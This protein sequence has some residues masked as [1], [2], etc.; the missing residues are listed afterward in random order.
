MADY[1][2]VQEDFAGDFRE[3]LRQ[4]AR[5]ANLLLKGVTNATGTVTLTA[6]AATTTVTDR[7]IHPDTQIK[8]TPTTANAATATGNVYQSAAATGSITLTHAN[9]GQTDRTFRYTLHG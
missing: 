8:L 2:P 7:R 6:G 5:V 3:W 1:R 9:N 4:I